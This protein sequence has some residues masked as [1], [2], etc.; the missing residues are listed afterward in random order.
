[1]LQPLD[2]CYIYI[3]N[4]KEY[5]TSCIELAH[6]RADEGTK[7]KIVKLNTIN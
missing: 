7:I 1:M 5:F 6:K 4:G 2:E 3:R